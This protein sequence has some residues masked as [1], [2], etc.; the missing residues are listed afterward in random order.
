[1]H[2]G[3]LIDY[4]VGT[5]HIAYILKVTRK[6][7]A[8]CCGLVSSSIHAQQNKV[9]C[10]SR[11]LLIV[12]ACACFA[13]TSYAV[14]VVTIPAASD[15]TMYQGQFDG[16]P[17]DGERSNA[18][19]PNIWTGRGADGNI[20]R[21]TIFFD[22]ESVIPSDATI[23]FARLELVVDRS[24]PS[25]DNASI[26]RLT[27][28][29]GAGTSDASLINSG[30]RGTNATPGDVTLTHNFFPT[31]TWTTIGGDFIAAPSA[32]AGVIPPSIF[33]FHPPA[34]FFSAGGLIEADI[35][36]WI[37]GAT[38][39]YGWIIKGSEAVPLSAKR[40]FSADT[41]NVLERPML[42]VAFFT[43]TLTTT[44][45]SSTSTTTTTSTTSTTSTTTTST[46]TTTL[47]FVNT[48]PYAD[49]FEAMPPYVD[50]FSIDSTNGWIGKPG[51][52]VIST[53]DAL[54][55]AL[56]DFEMSG[57]PLPI[58]GAHTKILC[59]TPDLVTLGKPRE[60]MRIASKVNGNTDTVYVDLVW[61]PRLGAE[62]KSISTNVHLACYP[63]TNGNLVI[64]H[65]YAGT[66]EW[67][68]LVDSPIISTGEWLRVTIE[69]NF[70][71]T[72]W[73][74]RVNGQPFI[75]DPKGWDTVQGLMHP[76]TWF[77][78]VQKDP[79]MSKLGFDGESYV[80][81][82]VVQLSD[83]F[84][85]TTTSTTTFT[86][87]TTSTTTTS[88]TTS[89]TSTTTTS[90]TSSTS[91]TSTTTLTPPLIVNIDPDGTI[92]AVYLPT[93]IISSEYSTN[94][95]T[96]PIEWLPLSISSNTLVDGTNVIEFDQPD[97]NASPVY[98][99]LQRTF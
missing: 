77:D 98:F 56:A 99:R 94:L 9:N 61:W 10:S 40:Y 96:I 91:S 43:P 44:L 24:Q 34:L 88:T 69:Q 65:D 13:S 26:H 38:T 54:N 41:T 37:D 59:I 79:L 51:A 1:M 78:M 47:P 58:P 22:V 64:W 87:T 60:P 32:S 4:R 46:T 42:V 28:D 21:S 93:G 2:V 85:T 86:S 76:G 66:P 11:A 36:G 3:T 57:V 31:S 30:G 52:A 45:T 82:V 90:S 5:I 39:N 7:E 50:G 16:G 33:D 95:S 55:A 80:D 20:K 25:G 62:P 53:N 67:L 74:L 84:T 27:S 49:P 92:W 63:N 71:Y 48:M 89:T 12:I 8:T 70:T 75:S 23:T 14:E 81:D 29:W 68:S 72:R 35:Q 17:P 6:L 15:N 73:R 19:G 83:P 97:T 18:L